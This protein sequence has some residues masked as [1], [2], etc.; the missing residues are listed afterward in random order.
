MRFANG[1]RNLHRRTESIVST[2]RL[3]PHLPKIFLRD[4]TQSR[5]SFRVNIIGNAWINVNLIAHWNRGLQQLKTNYS[6][7][8]RSESPTTFADDIE[9]RPSQ[10]A[11]GI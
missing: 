1:N 11:S 5:R 6:L 7:S 8:S 10:P 4:R 2:V 3:N 9:T